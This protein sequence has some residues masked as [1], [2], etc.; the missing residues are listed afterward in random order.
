[1]GRVPPFGV[2][3]FVSKAAMPKRVGIVVEIYRFEGQARCVVRFE[4]DSESVFFC[5]WTCRRRNL[6]GVCFASSLFSR[7]APASS[8]TIYPNTHHSLGDV[9]TP[10]DGERSYRRQ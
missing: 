1:M 10:Q 6:G 5:L 8:T 4:D 3:D 7:F 9:E 2:G